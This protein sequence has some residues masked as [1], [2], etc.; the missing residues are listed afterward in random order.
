MPT[1]G[2]RALRRA[3]NL[4]PFG[5]TLA[6]YVVEAWHAARFRA[7]RWEQLPRA[8]PLLLLCICLLDVVVN[9]AL[10]WVVVAGPARFYPQAIAA[11]WFSVAALALA[12]WSTRFAASVERIDAP[13]AHDAPRDALHATTAASPDAASLFALALLAALII[14]TLTSAIYIPL[15]RSDVFAGD[16]DWGTVQWLLQWLAWGAGAVWALA[17]NVALLTRVVRHVNADANTTISTSTLVNGNVIAVALLMSATAIQLWATPVPFWYPDEAQ[18]EREKSA[19]R[20]VSS[21]LKPANLLKQAGVFEAALKA[22]PAERPGV[23]DTYVI[24]YSPYAS[25]DVFLK[26]S[27]V[28]TG[29][30]AARFGTGAR[31]LRLV[32][33]AST[34]ATLPWATPENLQ[35]AIAHVGSLMN[36]A[37]D[38]LFIH[39]AS[40]G[41][42]DGQLESRFW[43]LQIGNLGA[44]EV[45]TWLDDAGVSTRIISVSACYSG[46]WVPALK[47]PDTLVMTA[48][49]AE[50]TSYGCGAKSELTYFTRAVFA[51]QLAVST[52]SF[53]KALAA[54]RPIIEAREIEGGKKDG[55]SNPQ[56]DVGVNA[57]ARIERWI[58]EIEAQTGALRGL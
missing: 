6:R 46:G 41:G 52:R 11:G 9:V 5:E 45:R 51:E 53:E 18:G 16:G 4:A 44:A 38:L 15:Y 32:N 34:V 54:A 43:P 13:D 2:A 36:P 22:L 3:T 42:S 37:E 31:T 30:M 26:E 7:P 8:T 33:H 27:E 20:A 48:S 49:D 28:V 17:A 12:C 10:Q 39:F 1:L 21:H 29:V 35:A 57:K 50:H 25:E 58:G 19:A 23:V 40:H 47:S 14:N 56:I 55:F 24:T